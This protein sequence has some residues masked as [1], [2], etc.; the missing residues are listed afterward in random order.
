MVASEGFIIDVRHSCKEIEV[1]LAESSKK[2]KKCAAYEYYEME[3]SGT[4][5]EKKL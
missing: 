5:N 3:W 2:F 4:V 1:H